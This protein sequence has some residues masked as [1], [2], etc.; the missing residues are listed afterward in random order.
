MFKELH[1]HGKLMGFTLTRGGRLYFFGT[2]HTQREDLTKLFPRF[3]FLFLK[4]VHG[5]ELV[6]AEPGRNLREADGHFTSRPGL[7]LV[8]QSADC[9]PVLL[10][11][12]TRVASVHAGWKGMALNIIAAAKAKMPGLN[13]AALGPHIMRESFEVGR[14]VGAQLMRAAPR[15]EPSL[16][17]DAADPAKQFFDL[18]R[19]AELQLMYGLSSDSELQI[20]ECCF[21]TKTNTLFHSYRRGRASRERQYSFVVIAPEFG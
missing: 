19:L 13:F 17:V 18:K 9:L 1:A 12:P 14:D 2:G 5:R 8:C 4:Q 21:D 3:E 20:D 6:E 11:S 15:P 7:A 16:A 10:S